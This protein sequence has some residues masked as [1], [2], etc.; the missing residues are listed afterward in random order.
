MSGSKWFSC[1]W[2]GGVCVCTSSTCS[3]AVHSSVSLTTPSVGLTVSHWWELGAFWAFPEPV[4]GPR[5]AHGSVPRTTAELLRL[6]QYLIFQPLLPRLLVCELFAANVTY[7]PGS[8]NE[9]VGLC[10]FWTNASTLDHAASGRAEARLWSQASRETSRRSKQVTNSYTQG[11]LCSVQH[12]KC[13][14]LLSRLPLS[15]GVW[16]GSEVSQTPEILWFLLGFTCF[17]E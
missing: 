12:R 10:Q 9:R 8:S 16:N 7:D 1:L 6:L 4:H 11:P 15:K 13:R 3:Q 5:W 14:G 17:P 2:R